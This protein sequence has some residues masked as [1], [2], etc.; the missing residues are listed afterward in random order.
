MKWKEILPP[1]PC[2]QPWPSCGVTWPVMRRHMAP[3]NRSTHQEGGPSSGDRCR[4]WYRCNGITASEMCQRWREG[5]KRDLT[6]LHCHA[7]NVK[8]PT[9][10]SLALSCSNSEARSHDPWSE[11][12]SYCSQHYLS[13]Q[14]T[15]TQP[16]LNMKFLIQKREKWTT[17]F[18]HMSMIRPYTLRIAPLCPINIIFFTTVWTFLIVVVLFWRI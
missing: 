10:S 13:W 18:E 16:H 11:M 2:F 1:L 9:F 3:A 14:H 5:E 4:W 7:W 17:L 15:F 6:L 8:I 12:S